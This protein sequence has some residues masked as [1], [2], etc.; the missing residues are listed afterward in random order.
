MPVPIEPYTQ[1]IHDQNTDHYFD[2][3]NAHPDWSSH[4][5]DAVALAQK[6]NQHVLLLILRGYNLKAFFS[7][8][9]LSNITRLWAE[10][11]NWLRASNL[12][13]TL[14]FDT[15]DAPDGIKQEITTIRSQYPA[16]NDL[17]INDCMMGSHAEV[18]LLT[19]EGKVLDCFE[20]WEHF[21]TGDALDESARHRIEK[22]LAKAPIQTKHDPGH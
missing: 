20:K 18:W 2:F 15:S 8:D 21:S 22:A 3:F 1:N 11:G 10:G 6:N 14:Y 19:P 4:L 17:L 16:Q 5:K 13:P 7:T 12:V 9:R